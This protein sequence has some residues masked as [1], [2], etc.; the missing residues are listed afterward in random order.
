MPSPSKTNSVIVHLELD[1]L[2]H[3]TA[4]PRSPAVDAYWRRYIRNAGGRVPRLG[5]GLVY[6]QQDENIESFLTDHVPARKRADLRDGWP[7]RVRMG[8]ETWNAYIDCHNNV[9]G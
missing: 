2:G 6:V 4:E 3:L 7:V 8:R 9:Q 1:R 5:D